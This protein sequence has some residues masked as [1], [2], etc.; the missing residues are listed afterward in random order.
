[1]NLVYGNE[2]TRAQDAR[3][4]CEQRYAEN[5]LYGSYEKESKFRFRV[6]CDCDSSRKLR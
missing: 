3:L 2:L 5:L 4:L 6:N 1:V